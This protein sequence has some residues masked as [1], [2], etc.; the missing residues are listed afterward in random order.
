[1]N[2]V[3]CNAGQFNPHLIFKL[4]ETLA[5]LSFVTFFIYYINH[6]V[7]YVHKDKFSK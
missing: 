3:S 2:S 4:L 5:Y 6:K 7:G 1:M